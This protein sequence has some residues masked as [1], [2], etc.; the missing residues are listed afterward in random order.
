M[1]DHN[2]DLMNYRQYDRMDDSFEHLSDINDVHDA[3]DKVEE[4]NDTHEEV[5][6]EGGQH[7][8]KQVE[9]EHSSVDR[10]RRECWKQTRCR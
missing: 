9:E 1:D 5:A 3:S 4:E 2:F 10:L 7:V 8:Q 6:L